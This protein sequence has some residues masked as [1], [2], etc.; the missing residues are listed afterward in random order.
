MANKP[1][2]YAVLQVRR[3]ATQTEIDEAYKRLSAAYFPTGAGAKK[4]GSGRRALS[5][6]YRVLGD[7]RR[8]RKYDRE[9][10]RPPEG[11]FSPLSSTPVLIGYGVIFTAAV[12][13]IGVVLALQATRDDSPASVSEPTRFVTPPPTVT[14]TPVPTPTPEGQTPAPTLAPVSGETVTL[15]SGVEYIIIREGSGDQVTEEAVVVTEYSAWVQETG[16]MF[17]TTDKPDRGPFTIPI[18]FERV[19]AGWDE[20]I[21][22]MQMGEVRR[23]I[24]PPELAYGDRGTSNVP[25]NATVVFDIE[26]V[27]WDPAPTVPPG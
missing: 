8:R 26:L 3:D 1:D 10:S 4:S 17:D 18:G 19:I 7:P 9:L 12:A 25:P 21:V 14:I 2:H 13:T 16:Q 22:G 15:P 20:G 11:L 23:L 5:N 27:S 24:I 6:A